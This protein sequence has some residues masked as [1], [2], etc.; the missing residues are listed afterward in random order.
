M[1]LTAR[2]LTPG[3]CLHYLIIQLRWAKGRGQTVGYKAP[4]RAAIGTLHKT[5][6][7]SCQK[8]AAREKEQIE[9][10]A[11]TKALSAGGPGFPAIL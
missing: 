11:T 9:N 8:G 6:A 2:P 5:I 1:L 3:H 7:R 4:T 10:G